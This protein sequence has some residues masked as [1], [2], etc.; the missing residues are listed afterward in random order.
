MSNLKKIR[1]VGA[2]SFRADGKRD[3]RTLIVAFRN[4]ADAANKSILIHVFG[5]RFSVDLD[6]C[7][8]NF[9]EMENKF[10]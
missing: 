7:H 3:M 8:G 6:H 5:L 4:F 1:S 2:V 9:R 10:L